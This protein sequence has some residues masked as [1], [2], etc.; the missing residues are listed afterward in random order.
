MQGIGQITS[1]TMKGSK[2]RKFESMLG[3]LQTV[4]FDKGLD[5]NMEFEAD[6]SGMETAYRTGYDPSAM[7]EVLRSLKQVKKDS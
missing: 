2:G 7:I 1:A 4:L 6:K 5:K 3:D